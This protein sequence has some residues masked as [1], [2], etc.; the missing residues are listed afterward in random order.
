MK[1]ITLVVLSLFLMVGFS[2]GQEQT[3]KKKTQQGHTDQNKFRQYLRH[4]QA[5]QKSR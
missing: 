1:K 4:A 2:Y 3:K 5:K